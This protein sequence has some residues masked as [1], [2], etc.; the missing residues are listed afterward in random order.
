MEGLDVGE[1][2]ARAGELD[3]LAGDGLYGDGRAA[4][5]VAVQLGEDNAVHAQ[6]LVEGVGHGDRVLAG[7]GVYYQQDLGGL[8][9][10]LD[11][12]ELVHELLVYVQTARG[13]DYHGVEAVIPGPVH[14]FLRDLHGI[15]LAL[16]EDLDPG[17]AAHYLQLADGGG[18]VYVARG[19]HGLFALFHQ[20]LAYLGAH[21]GLAR[22]LQAAHH[23]Y[24]GHGGG[25]GELHVLA[26]HEGC[27]LFVDYLYD[28]LGG[29]EGFQYVAAHGAL[30]DL[31]GEVLDDGV[32]DVRLQQR[33][34]HVAHRFLYVGF[35]ELAPGGQFFERSLYFFRK[36][37]KRH[38]CHLPSR[39]SA[40]WFSPLLFVSAHFRLRQVPVS[41]FPACLR[42][43]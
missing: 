2:F 14:R 20:H 8:Y 5:G 7:H 25:T 36:T 37:F 12:F 29:G 27:E 4:A 41:R 42:T 30:G 31:F 26:A 38:F 22:A 24:G 28:L 10:G 43:G 19:E 21:G 11:V 9:G 6:F 3:G 16:L 33:H 17:L 1:L 39:Y 40:L 15:A 13:V 18:T 23:V 35:G 32:V 34:A